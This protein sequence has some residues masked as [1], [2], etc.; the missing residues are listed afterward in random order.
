M[1]RLTQKGIDGETSA[2]GFESHHRHLFFVLTK[3]KTMRSFIQPASINIH[4]CVRME[5]GRLEEANTSF[6]RSIR[7]FDDTGNSFEVVAFPKNEDF[8]IQVEAMKRMPDHIT[9][10]PDEDEVDTYDEAEDTSEDERQQEVDDLKSTVI[11]IARTLGEK[12]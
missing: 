4:N 1:R 11:D 7:F 3:G 8:I 10:G 6:W 5:I 9:D 12:W 2:R